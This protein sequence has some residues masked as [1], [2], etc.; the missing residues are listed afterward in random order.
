LPRTHA[1]DILH[2]K[3]FDCPA[4]ADPKLG[5]PYYGFYSYNMDVLIVKMA[6][7]QVARKQL[8]IPVPSKTFLLGCSGF[9]RGGGPVGWGSL[10]P[11]A[12]GK[13]KEENPLLGYYHPGNSCN[14]LM[15]DGHV[16]SHTYEEGVPPFAARDVYSGAPIRP[17]EGP[18]YLY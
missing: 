10:L 1:G 4:V 16:E 12:W 9:H 14:F 15:A 18:C 8:E 3:I 13:T 5:S 7:W 2:H 6:T 17:G 11:S